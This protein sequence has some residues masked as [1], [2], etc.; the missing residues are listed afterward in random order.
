[1]DQEG[2]AIVSQTIETLGEALPREMARVR[3]EVLPAYI[4]IGSPGLLAV[5]LMQHDLGRAEHA[6]MF[7]DTVEMIRVYESLKGYKT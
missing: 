3:D 7:G 2:V 6:I 5:S 4:E 1:M